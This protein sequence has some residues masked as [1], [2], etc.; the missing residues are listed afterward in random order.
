MLILILNIFLFSSFG[1][2]WKS[3]FSRLKE[4]DI[5][6][7]LIEEEKKKRRLISLSLFFC[8][9]C[10]NWDDRKNYEEREREQQNIN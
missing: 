1:L 4:C 10:C 8:R 9:R 6:V 5:L 2:Y 3:I 7:A